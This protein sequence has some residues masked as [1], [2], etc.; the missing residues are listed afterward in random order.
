MLSERLANRTLYE[1]RP[2]K[3]FD[4][5]T[6]DAVNKAM[7]KLVLVMRLLEVRDGLSRTDVEDLVI[8]ALEKAEYLYYGLEEHELM[9]IAGKEKDNDNVREKHLKS[10]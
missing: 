8:S 10:L 9:Q 3:S 1:W 7:R 5:E 6:I 2:D 4:R